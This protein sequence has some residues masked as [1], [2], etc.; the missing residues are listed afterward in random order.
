MRRVGPATIGSAS[1]AGVGCTQIQAYRRVAALAAIGCLMAENALRFGR[2]LWLPA[3]RAEPSLWQSC[4]MAHLA[5]VK[6]LADTR[7]T[8]PAATND[9]MDCAN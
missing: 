2:R 4:L 6:Y 7:K 8:G 1:V 5:R 9:R 3:T